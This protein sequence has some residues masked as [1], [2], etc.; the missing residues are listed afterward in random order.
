MNEFATTSV[1]RTNRVVS[2]DGMIDKLLT[3]RNKALV[4]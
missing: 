2:S 4:T 3:I 1:I